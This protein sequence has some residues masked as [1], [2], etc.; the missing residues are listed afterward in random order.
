MH[1]S[2]KRKLDLIEKLQFDVSMTAVYAVK[3]VK[4]RTC[5]ISENKPRSSEIFIILHNEKCRPRNT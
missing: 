4:K 1:Y 3:G 2:V 5:L